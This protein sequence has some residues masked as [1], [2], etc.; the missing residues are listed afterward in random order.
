MPAE[1]VFF[2]VAGNASYLFDI[3]F[4]ANLASLSN[5]LCA[6]YP[7]VSITFLYQNNMA[8]IQV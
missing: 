5:A 1:L 2:G 7:D 4:A 3:L 8:G 6:H